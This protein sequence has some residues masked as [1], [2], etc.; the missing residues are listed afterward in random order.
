MK[1]LSKNLSREEMK[2]IVGAT[3]KTKWACY[4]S[5]GVFAGYVC[6]STNPQTTCGFYL[7]TDTGISC[8]FAFGCP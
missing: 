8:T 2:K 7:C 6:T 1:T 3:N 4:D 5:P